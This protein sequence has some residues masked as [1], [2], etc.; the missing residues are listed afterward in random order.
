MLYLVDLPPP[1]HGMSAMNDKFIDYLGKGC[2][3]NTSPNFA[4]RYFNSYVWIICK[5]LIT[6]VVLIS[7]LIA[8]IRGER[9]CYR[10]INGGIGQVF[11]I[12]YLSFVRIFNLKIII[13]HHSFNYLSEKKILFKLISKIIGSKAIHVVLGDR[14]K[15]ELCSKYNIKPDQ[16]L[17]ISNS[18]FFAAEKI[19]RSNVIKKNITLGYISNLTLEKGVGLFIN[20]CISLRGLGYT[21]DATIAGPISGDGVQECIDKFSYNSGFNYLGPVYDKDKQDFL[22]NIDIFVFPSRYKNEAEPLVLYE[23][24]AYGARLVATN[25]GCMADVVTSL[26]GDV[27]LIDENLEENLQL[28]VSQLLDEYTYTDKLLLQKVFLDFID[29]NRL[30]LSRLKKEVLGVPEA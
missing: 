3:I 26:M 28:K 7:L 20:M 30:S 8:M 11:D 21:F 17:I 16:V 4:N 29:S 9:I 6:P 27:I 15:L 24:A 1:V 18:V 25:A 23:A 22:K 2:V 10:S 13:H 12:L 5:L 19:D 14:M